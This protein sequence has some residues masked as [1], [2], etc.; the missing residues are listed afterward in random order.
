[1]WLF[2]IIYSGILFYFFVYISIFPKSTPFYVPLSQPKSIPCSSNVTLYS[3]KNK[4]WIYWITG[5]IFYNYKI[6]FVVYQDDVYK[7]GNILEPEIIPFCLIYIQYILSYGLMSFE[8]LFLMYVF[9]PNFPTIF[10]NLCPFHINF[11]VLHL[12]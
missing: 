12:L 4:F 7:N 5:N 11:P 1:M 8:I 6:N 9:F 2:D 3:W 10:S